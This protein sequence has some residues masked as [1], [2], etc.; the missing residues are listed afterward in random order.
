LV[1]L[2]CIVAIAQRTFDP[3]AEPVSE[4]AIAALD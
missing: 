4:G 2:P 1:P 3:P